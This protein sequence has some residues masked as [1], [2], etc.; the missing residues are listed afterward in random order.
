VLE[1]DPEQLEKIM[2][3]QSKRKKPTNSGHQNL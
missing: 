2:N 3:S 1:A